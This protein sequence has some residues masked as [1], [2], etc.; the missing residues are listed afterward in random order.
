[1]PETEKYGGGCHCGRV[2]YEVETDLGMVLSCNCSVCTKRGAL[3]AYV[4]PDQFNLLSGKGELADY[5]FNK[6]TIHHL[7]CRH[8]GVGSFSTGKGEDGSEGIG[9]NVRCLDG[10][11]VDALTLTPFDGKK[12]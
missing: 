12:L 5:Q 8:C 2:R 3:W 1:M 4:G 10:V 9:I 6:K 7:F 11:D